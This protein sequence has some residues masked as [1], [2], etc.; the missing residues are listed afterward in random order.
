MK[1]GNCLNT[2]CEPRA[3]AIKYQKVLKESTAIREYLSFFMKLASS[4][5]SSEKQI[6]TS[7]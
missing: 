5:P 6:E 1:R 7:A 4:M 3:V 2:K